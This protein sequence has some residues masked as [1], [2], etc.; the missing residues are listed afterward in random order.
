MRRLILLI[1]TTLLSGEIALFALR[2]AVDAQELHNARN[3]TV[4]PV[5]S[6]L[7]IRQENVVIQKWDISCGAAALATIL[8]YQYGDSISERKIAEG[9]LRRTDPLRV[10]F[11][12]GFSLL[13]LKRFA[14]ARGYIADGYAD[15][16]VDDLIKLGPSIVP[17]KLSGYDHF[18]VF[19]GV[20]GPK[21]LLADPGF[22]N[23]TVPLETFEE[24][25]AKKIAFV[26][27]G[28]SRGTP[29][30]NNFAARED[31]FVAPAAIAL[32]TAIRPGRPP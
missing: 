3:R 2:G 32:R 15:L 14:E 13:D 11:R 29:S 7:E 25:W 27:S 23:R 17:V 30:T 18:V 12:G 16:T 24:V 1:A 9:M 22:G 6:L 4:R 21:V 10:K 31:D 5:R 28:T 8:T 20:V 26:V 19:R